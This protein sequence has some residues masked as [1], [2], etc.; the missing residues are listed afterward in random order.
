VANTHS[1]MVLLMSF[2]RL[3][4]AFGNF[5]MGKIRKYAAAMAVVV[6]GLATPFLVAAQT[7]QRSSPKDVPRLSDIMSAVQFR[8][9]KLWAAGQKQNWELAAY[10][11]DQVK[12]GL[13]EAITL[14]TEIP[15]TS[16]SVIETPLKSINGAIST[17]NSA[18]FGKSF[19]GLTAACNSCH[20]SIGRGFIFITVPTTSPFSN[21]LFSPR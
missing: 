7:P 1:I 9:L 16:F 19:K 8:H 18:E 11:L 21:Q 10:E 12:A 3:R 2:F 17:K 13:A 15:V 5:D 6:V 14:Y 20:Q 4:I